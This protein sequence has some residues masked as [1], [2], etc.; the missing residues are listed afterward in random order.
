MDQVWIWTFWVWEWVK[1]VV[2]FT[3]TLGVTLAAVVGAAWAAFRWFGQKWIESKF[4]KSLEEYKAGQARE[5]EKL[6]HKINSTFDRITRLHDREFDVLP[7]LWGKLVEA[8]L[9][10]GAYIS[11]TQSYARVMYL[12]D[13][14]LREFLDGTRFT[15]WQ[16]REI[17]EAPNKQD[18]YIKTY[19]RYRYADVGG[20]LREFDLSF[21]KNGIF[22]HS[23]L[24][25][26][27][28]KMLD[29]IH[30]AV[31]EHNVNEE[32]NVRPRIRSASSTFENQGEAL[33]LKIKRAVSDR[34]WES[35]NKE[36]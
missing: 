10:A 9:W 18:Q 11:V 4:A 27:M 8:K 33:F 16:K 14:A 20:K 36:L 6:K 5:L 1:P 7:D 25:E 3:A 23:E 32:E 29:I 28:R 15:E 19:N 24:E 35:A 17:I 12:D 22:L 26:M 34:L 31:V 13:D 30:H 2:A 21:S